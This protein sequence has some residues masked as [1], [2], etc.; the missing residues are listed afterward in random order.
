MVQDSNFTL[1][2]AHDE[3]GL[4]SQHVGASSFPGYQSHAAPAAESGPSTNVHPPLLYPF[5]EGPFGIVIGQPGNSGWEH[6]DS[7][8][9][10]N[11]NEETRYD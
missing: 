2:E 10:D 6:R 4:S 9:R 3:W 1:P 7:G 11:E 5:A 8:V